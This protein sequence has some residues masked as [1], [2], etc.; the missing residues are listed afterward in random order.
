VNC[1]GPSGDVGRA[2][3]PLIKSLLA[4]GHAR[5]DVLRIGIDV[6]EDY[7][8]IAASGPALEHLR[9]VGPLLRARWWEATAVPELRHHASQLVKAWMPTSEGLRKPA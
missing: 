7:R 1:T 8:L 5:P 3:D 9:Y 6:S 2:A 4:R